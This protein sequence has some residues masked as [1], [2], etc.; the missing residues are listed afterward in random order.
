MR[1]TE[2]G[3]ICIFSCFYLPNIRT[4]L[5]VYSTYMSTCAYYYMLIISCIFL[6][7]SCAIHLNSNLPLLCTS[8]SVGLERLSV[9]FH[10]YSNTSQWRVDLAT[11]LLKTPVQCEG[12]LSQRWTTHLEQGR[13]L[14]VQLLV[15][16]HCVSTPF[17]AYPYC[18]MV[19]VSL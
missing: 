3:S 11:L 13:L 15:T 8:T 19:A 12:P 7:L 16:P 4:Y 9:F 17:W 18:C 2:T 6:L 1:T 10:C 14:Y 5:N